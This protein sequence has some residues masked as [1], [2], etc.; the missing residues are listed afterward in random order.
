MHAMFEKFK[1]TL[2][3]DDRSALRCAIWL[4]MYCRKVKDVHRPCF[5]IVVSLSPDNLSAMAPPVR[6]E[7]TPTKSG[8]MPE[9]CSFRV[10][11]ALL[12][13]VHMFVAVTCV[14]LL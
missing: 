13:V 12:M 10:V 3:F 8:L 7:C 6:N 4:W 14:H 11:T 1:T 5:I 9:R 2:I